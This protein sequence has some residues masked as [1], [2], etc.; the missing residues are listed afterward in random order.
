MRVGVFILCAVAALALPSFSVAETSAS[1]VNITDLRKAADKK[2]HRDS[3]FSAIS[4]QADTTFKPQ[5]IPQ[6]KTKLEAVASAPMDLTI[7]EFHMIDYFPRRSS[8][9]ASGNG[10]AGSM[11]YQSLVDSKTNKAA[12][13]NLQVPNNEDSVVCILAGTLNNAPVSVS[14]FRIY[15]LPKLAIL[16]HTNKAFVEAASGCIDDLAH[17]L[18][19]S[20]KPVAPVQASN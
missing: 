9:V 7:S 18:S 5:P 8:A 17:Q 16:V 15:K 2:H 1:V 12:L 11:I 6:L 10:W 19:D 14:S 4:F 20:M 3:V 13:E